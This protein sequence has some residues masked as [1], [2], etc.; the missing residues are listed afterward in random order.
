MQGQMH[1]HVKVTFGQELPTVPLVTS[2]M[3]V[4]YLLYRVAASTILCA[5]QPRQRSKVWHG[6]AFAG[7]VAANRL[8][9]HHVVFHD[10]AKATCRA[11]QLSDCIMSTVTKTAGGIPTGF[12]CAW[13]TCMTP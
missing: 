7:V 4:A 11:L 5:L 13:M 3:V 2:T 9:I 8:H 12:R 6:I 1:A 10:A